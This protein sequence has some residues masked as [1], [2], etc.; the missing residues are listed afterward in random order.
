MSKLAVLSFAALAFSAAAHATDIDVQLGSTER[1]TRLFAFPNNCNV[2]CFRDWTLE[3][4]VEHYLTQSVQ[5][6]GYGTAKVHVKIDND[7]VYAS[8]SGVP[9]SYGQPL[10]ALLDAGDLAYNGASKLN[11]DKKWSY[12]WYLFLPLGMA[13]EN[14][15][16]VELLHFPPDYSL[17]QAQDYL[18][19]A[20][21]DRWATL[22]TVNGIAVEQTP[23][24]QTIIDIAPIAAPSNAGSTLEGL[25]SYF[26]DYQ[27][28]MVT[29]VTQAASGAALPM[30][31]FGAPVRNWIKTQY[32][33]T[34]NVLSLAT[35]TTGSGVKVPVLG[36]NHPSYIWYAA[37]KDSYDGDEA[38][39]DAA[40]LKVMGQDLSASCWQAGMGS[41]PG[42]DPS[43]LLNQ[44]TQTWQV[45]QK[46]KTCELFYTSIRN[47][48]PDEAAK[49]CETPAIK[50]QLPQL[51]V[52]M[53]LPAEAV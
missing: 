8:I 5:R 31:A 44:C 4:T 50:S 21:T 26:N 20:T 33:Q 45:T 43:T 49:K 52:P 3:Q 17:T 27:T 2:I 12:N 23:A 53:P 14:R 1:V 47:L 18:E 25:Y 16:S 29:Q 11:S 30:V 34:V 28:T 9:K 22:L 40:G 13:L 46:E 19:S 39:A 51:K 42:T 36:S 35:I 6:D 38:K 15:K 10:K 32:G 7:K 41:K 48:T 37:D 24:Y